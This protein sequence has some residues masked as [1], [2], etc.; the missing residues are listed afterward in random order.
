MLVLSNGHRAEDTYDARLTGSQTAAT[1]DFYTVSRLAD[2]DQVVKYAKI[3]GVRS[4]S[5]GDFVCSM[6]RRHGGTGSPGVSWSFT[7]CLSLKVDLL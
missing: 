1:C 5:I 7:S 4:L 2:V 6:V 3:D